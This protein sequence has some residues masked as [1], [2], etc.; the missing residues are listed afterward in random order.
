[1]EKVVLDTSVVVKWF[2]EEKDSEKA[3][4]FLEAYQ[5]GRLEIIAPEIMGLELTNALF[6]GAGY[7]GEV[8]KQAL[9]AFY[10]LKLASVPLSESFVQEARKYMEKFKI[11]IYD[12]L[13]IALADRERLPL[14]SADKQHH[15]KRFSK[16][17]KYL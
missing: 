7:K 17:I 3:Q 10:S 2:V 13:F 14:I 1:M 6:F 16:Q 9:A 8:L 5:D 11:A 15:Q 12:A 4:K